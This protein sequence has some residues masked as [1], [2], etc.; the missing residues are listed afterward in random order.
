MGQHWE[1]HVTSMPDFS[2]QEE[3]NQVNNSIVY[4]G[5][6]L[7]WCLDL[8]MGSGL[9]DDIGAG[10]HFYVLNPMYTLLNTVYADHRLISDFSENKRC[11]SLFSHN[12]FLAYLYSRC[13][14]CE[15]GSLVR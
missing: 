6:F 8:V 10:F 5:N 7:I 13:G 3:G 9:D 15:K 12:P 4:E 2:T 11:R 14:K 1:T